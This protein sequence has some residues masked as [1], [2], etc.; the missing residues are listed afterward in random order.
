MNQ[1]LRAASNSAVRL[2]D[3]GGIEIFAGIPDYYKD[4]I[5][6]PPTTIYNPATGKYHFSTP[7]Q[8]T[9]PGSEAYFTSYHGTLTLPMGA[10]ENSWIASQFTAASWI[11]LYWAFGDASGR[12]AGSYFPHYANGS[13]AP[14]GI[15]TYNG[16]AN[17][18]PFTGDGPLDA[19]STPSAF[20]NDSPG[21]GLWYDIDGGR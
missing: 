19:L 18:N 16:Y 3:T 12:Y 4:N 15:N 8:M 10:E 21:S 2:L 20:I 6:L 1:Y 5:Q 14:G 11:G 9:W 7:S 17:W 13:F